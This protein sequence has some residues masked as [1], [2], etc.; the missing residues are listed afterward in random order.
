[1]HKLEDLLKIFPFEIEIEGKCEGIY[2]SKASSILE[3]D[4][5]SI[6]WIS[7]SKINKVEL[8]RNTLARIIICDK[9]IE[10]PED[11][12]LDKCFIKAD[13]PRFCFLKVINSFFK[14]HFEYSIHPT[15]VIHPE[16]QIHK[17]VYIGPFTYIG[18]SV[19]GSNVIIYGSTFIY[20]NVQIGDNVII[21]S[22]VNIGGDGF[23]FE[24]AEDKR[25]VKFEHIG[26]VNI[27]SDVEICSGCSVAQGTLSCTKIG[28]GTKLDQM[29]HIAHNV[30]IGKH[31]CIT[32]GVIFSGS[33][34]VGDFSWIGPNTSMKEGVNIG[35]NVFVGVGS[36]L[37]KDIP[38]NEVWAGN[39]AMPI[40]DLK[41]ILKNNQTIRN[42]NLK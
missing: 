7:S 11:L 12:L 15:S 1:M 13:N 39:P 30:I 2:F 23:G 32:A 27:E 5:E 42:S 37:T 17:D 10:I 20:D 22:G 8:A 24:R 41:K 34:K 36:V 35:N 28:M 14:K 3:A 40:D 4:S 19:I 25:L 26:G 16:A 31:C 38:D 29:V 18:K 33:V 21:H 6:V 9:S